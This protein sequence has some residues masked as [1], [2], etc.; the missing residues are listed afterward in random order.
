[1]LST[2][3]RMQL[4]SVKTILLFATFFA[5]FIYFELVESGGNDFSYKCFFYDQEAVIQ[6]FVDEK[7][8]NK[9]PCSKKDTKEIEIAKSVIKQYWK[10]SY[11]ERYSLFSMQYK[12][13]L[14]RVYK[15]TNS[16]EYEN[17][18]PPSE[19]TWQK[20][21]YEKSYKENNFIQIV[22]LTT[23]FEEGYQGVMTYIFDMLKE[24]GNWRIANIKY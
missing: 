7:D 8:K 16:K 2:L 19:R 1:M 12:E 14:K 6:H 13:M 5:I 18:F 17:H 9:K 22:V 24:D 11:S 4:L 3:K 23:W 21:I 20:Q 10:A 15:I